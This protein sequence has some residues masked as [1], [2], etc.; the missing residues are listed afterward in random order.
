M[1]NFWETVSMRSVGLF[2]LLIGA[3]LPVRADAQVF[4]TLNTGGVDQ[5]QSINKDGTNFQV[6]LPSL[7]SSSPWGIA[8]DVPGNN[9][10]WSDILSPSF[11]VYRST[12]DGLNV[13]SIYNAPAPVQSISRHTESGNLYLSTSSQIIR[14]G[15]DGANATPLVTGLSNAWGV[16]VDSTAGKVYW[17]EAGA[18]RI[19]RANLDGSNIETVVDTTYAAT[20]T[21][22]GLTLDGLGGI[23]WADSATD[24]I[25]HANVG[26]FTGT[27][28]A[29]TPIVNLQMVTGG[30]STV[31][32]L[33]SDGERLYWA[34]GLSGV[35]G[36]YAAE[37][38]GA[39]P[40]AL[41]LVPIGV[42]A[43]PIGV[44]VSP[45]PEPSAVLAL[46]A[47]AWLLARRGRSVFRCHAG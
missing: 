42:N 29:A 23:Y 40:L 31:N 24:F 11:H 27:P 16:A 14:I 3:L 22:R 19:A 8:I 2:T 4:W 46:S 12:V 38:T 37:L 43:S 9:L 17:S 7:P 47:G 20:T 5:I 28:V 15:P 26:A 35:R 13:T 21:E 25:Y 36:V 33:T 41:Y 30:G 6:P 1:T 45:V 39:N 44:A 10:Y 34:E 32:G 18:N